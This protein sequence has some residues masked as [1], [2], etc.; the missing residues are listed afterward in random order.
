LKKP[1]N[2]RQAVATSRIIPSKA[3]SVWLV[4]EREERRS[5][6]DTD[7][8]TG[9]REQREDHHPIRNV[10]ETPVSERSRGHGRYRGKEADGPGLLHR[11]GEEVHQ[12]RDS[13]L[14][15]G[16]AEETAGGGDEE[17]G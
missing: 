7:D 11:H 5:D 8:G 17:P 2:V 3:F 9:P 13:H 16:H 4:H 12:G 15:T 6:E 1:G 14:A 10:P